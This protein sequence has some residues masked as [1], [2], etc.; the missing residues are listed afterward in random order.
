MTLATL[1]PREYHWFVNELRLFL[2]LLWMC[3]TPDNSAG[4]WRV[5]RL[6][7]HITESSAKLMVAERMLTFIRPIMSCGSPWCYLLLVA[8]ERI[9]CQ[10]ESQKGEQNLFFFFLEWLYVP[11]KVPR[12]IS[13]ER[14]C[15]GLSPLIP[16]S[17]FL[18]YGSR[19]LNRSDQ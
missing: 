10:Y 11:E 3:H 16:I 7:L 19:S 14:S 18:W 12:I 15:V 6:W 9:P 4:Q 8:N 17:L 1:Y 13:E 5:Y 2:L